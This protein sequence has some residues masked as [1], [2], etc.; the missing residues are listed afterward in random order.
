MRTILTPGPDSSA[1]LHTVL[2]VNR[3]F[4]NEKWIIDS[5]GSQYGFQDVLIPFDK[6]IKGKDGRISSEPTT[7]DAVETKDLDYF[8]TLPFMVANRAQWDNLQVDRRA[9]L[10]F[11][12]FVDTFVDKDIVDGGDVQFEAKFDSF[13]AALK[14]HLMEIAK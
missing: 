2:R 10:H 6:Y 11:A 13:I 14:L 5:T 9:R 3:L 12:A 8:E 7:Y 4:V 1:C